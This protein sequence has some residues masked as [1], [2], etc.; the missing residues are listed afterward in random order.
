MTAALMKCLVKAHDQHTFCVL[1]GL[2]DSHASWRELK[3][4]CAVA[5]VKLA[6]S[7]NSFFDEL[8]AEAKRFSPS[9]FTNILNL[10]IGLLPQIQ[11]TIPLVQPTVVLTTQAPMLDVFP[12][13]DLP[14]SRPDDM[15][16]DDNGDD[17][18]HILMVQTLLQKQKEKIM[19]MIQRVRDLTTKRMVKIG[20]CQLKTMMITL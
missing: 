20:T 18:I 6:E 13:R 7:N 15:G 16:D 10:S 5:E 2:K 19:T 9:V 12:T 17:K 8:F 4:A 1:T 14:P 11:H 3:K